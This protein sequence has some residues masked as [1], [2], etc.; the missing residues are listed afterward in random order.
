[1]ILRLVERFV[2]L[3]PNALSYFGREP[4]TFY[5]LLVVL[6]DFALGEGF[7]KE[8][9]WWEKWRKSMSGD[10]NQTSREKISSEIILISFINRQ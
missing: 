2:S 3:G 5:Q 1:M 8:D 6:P 4:V 10:D 9:G 7:S